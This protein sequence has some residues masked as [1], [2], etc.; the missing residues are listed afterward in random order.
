MVYVSVPISVLR[1]R[2]TLVKNKRDCLH[3]PSY[4]LS[5]GR[6]SRH[7]TLNSH[8]K[9]TLGSL[10]LHPVLEPLGLCR[11]DGKRP[12]GVTMILW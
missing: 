9:Q 7:V 8:I 3:G 11:T 6:Y 5:A 12:D 1:R 10:D 2:A 4:T